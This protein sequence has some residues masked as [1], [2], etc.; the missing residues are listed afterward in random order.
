MHTRGYIHVKV[1]IRNRATSA[2]TELTQGLTAVTL[3]TV[4]GATTITTPSVIAITVT[5]GKALE[6]F[7]YTCQFVA[8]ASVRARQILLRA[9]LRL[10]DAN[11]ANV[12]CDGRHVT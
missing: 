3:R 6:T 1:F 2:S 9:L 12:R 7:A 11:C 5:R 8:Y 4:V 10:S